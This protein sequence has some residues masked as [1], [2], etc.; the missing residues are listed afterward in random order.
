MIVRLHGRG[1]LIMPEDARFAELA[2]RFPGHSGT[3]GI[4]LVEVTRVSDS[5]GWGVPHF[6]FTEDREALEKWA[7]GK[8]P[9]GLADYHRQKNARSIDGLPA[10]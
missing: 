9:E 8:G 3:R 5:C 10:L 7:A 2:A 6:E 1:V 4:V